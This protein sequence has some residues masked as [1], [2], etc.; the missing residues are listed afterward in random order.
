VGD[1]VAATGCGLLVVG[2][3]TLTAVAAP[4]PRGLPGMPPGTAQ[5]KPPGT[6]AGRPL[7]T[8]LRGAPLP[9]SGLRPPGTAMKPPGTA[10]GGGGGDSENAELLLSSVALSVLRTLP[11]PTIVVTANTRN[12]LKVACVR[13]CVPCFELLGH[14]CS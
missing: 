13:A 1:L 11:I 7:G 12:Y 5:G 2:S 14:A 6:S 4:L 8:P 9:G 10:M 3:H